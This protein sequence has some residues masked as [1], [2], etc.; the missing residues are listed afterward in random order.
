MGVSEHVQGFLPEG[1]DAF[2][3][4]YVYTAFS[5]TVGLFLACSSAYGVWKIRQDK[6]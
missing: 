3:Q 1:A 5:P 2:I 6:A 4:D